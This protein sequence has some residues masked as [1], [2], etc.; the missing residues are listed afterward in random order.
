MWTELMVLNVEWFSPFMRAFLA[1]AFAVFALLLVVLEGLSVPVVG[2]SLGFGFHALD[3]HRRVV[4]S[5]TPYAAKAGLRVGDVYD[6]AI[7]PQGIRIEQFEDLRV[8]PFVLPVVR[9]GKLTPITVIAQ[10]RNLQE[11]LVAYADI[12]MKIVGLAV[13]ILLIARGRGAFGLFAGLFLIGMFAYEGFN[14]SLA[15]IPPPWGDIT[16][17]ATLSLFCGAFLRYFSVE[18]MI[19]L[20][21]DG[22][23][24]WERIFFRSAQALGCAMMAADMA[25]YLAA[26]AGLPFLPFLHHSF[27]SG[28]LVQLSFMPGYAIA[29]LRPATR[30]R[31]AIAWV[32]WSSLI[33]FIGGYTNLIFDLQ[34]SSVPAYGAL[35]LTF[36]VMA[37]GFAY[38]ALRYRIVDLSFVVNRALVYGIMLSVIVGGLIVTE[39]LVTN[40]AIGTEKS[41]VI[42]IVVALA[43]GFSIKSVET[44][45]DHVVERV[46]FARKF[47]EEEGLRA[48]IRD[49][50]HVEN[51]DR[52]A[53]NVSEEA[54]RLI[55]AQHVAVYERSGDWLKPLASSPEIVPMM[56]VNIDD[57]VVVRMRSA[58]TEI[59]LGAL[60]STLGNDGIVF[61]MLARGRV[62]GVLACGNKPGRQDYDPDERKLLFDLAHEAGTSLLLLR[63]GALTPLAL[64]EA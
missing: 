38:V 54:R 35:N 45:I 2:G 44:R 3:S 39:T 20:C 6:W 18:A 15:I 42:Q 58:L 22:L 62:V 32:F 49:C 27:L 25:N 56:P 33:G 10:P 41:T 50:A 14:T 43:L 37:F 64:D 52:L 40:F 5:V 21:G 36:F 48:L 59:E 47:A 53:A 7:A 28:Q 63:S 11:Q 13:G 9:A 8:G 61:P 4:T 60:R 51:P 12:P 29:L 16:Y 55:G 24:R 31:S 34:S 57:P 19:A 17:A 26:F 23:R 46:L 30:D 1:A